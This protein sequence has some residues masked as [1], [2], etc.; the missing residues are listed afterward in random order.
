MK[1]DA[2]LFGIVPYREAL[3][4]QRF[5][6]EERRADR[7]GDTL[8]LLEHPPVITLGTRGDRSDILVDEASLRAAGGDI[9]EI[10]RGGQVT[11]HGPGQLVGYLIVNLYEHQRKVKLFVSNIERSII[12]W[13]AE[14]H[15]IEARVDP[16][17]VGVWV[18][19]EKIAAVGISIKGGVTMHGFALNLN[20]DL[21]H[22]SWIVP[23][24]IVDKG[25][26][27]VAALRGV[28]VD[29]AEAKTSMAATVARVFGYESYSFAEYA[30]LPVLG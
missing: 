17:N 29:M 24:G 14:R 9:V 3:D 16:T 18:G 15:H 20:T 22:F 4:Y 26:T 12:E 13:L 10:E 30:G 6:C 5:L 21:S 19:D 8:L 28:A 2:R 7:I 25:I 27:S 1:L 11:Y 23:C